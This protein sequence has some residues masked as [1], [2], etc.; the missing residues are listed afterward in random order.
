MLQD[1][2]IDEAFLI[3][4]GVWGFLS[5]LWRISPLLHFKREMM[6]PVL[7][8]GPLCVLSHSK[9]WSAGYISREMGVFIKDVKA[10]AIISSCWAQKGCGTVPKLE[11]QAKECLKLWSNALCRLRGSC[12][13]GH[14]SGIFSLLGF[15]GEDCIVGLNLGPFFP[16]SCRC[17]AFFLPFEC[18]RQPAVEFFQFCLQPVCCFYQLLDCL[19]D[20]LEQRKTLLSKCNRLHKQLESIPSST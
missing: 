17:A 1:M 9:C 11:S 20:Y 16:A 19:L 18:R 8:M 13:L 5:S 4:L 15:F 3:C 12:G 7:G 14:T 2:L 10:N 6:N